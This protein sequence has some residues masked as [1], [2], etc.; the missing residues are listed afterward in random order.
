MP[1][2]NSN[3]VDS[4]SSHMLALETKPCTSKYKLLY[5][6]TANGSLEQLV[7]LMVFA[8]W[9][10]VVILWLIH[11]HVPLVY[12]NSTLSEK[13]MERNMLITLYGTSTLKAFRSER[14]WSPKLLA[15]SS[16]EA[17]SAAPRPQNSSGI[18][19]DR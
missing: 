17:S 6:G 4:A 5:D 13:I 11:A 16:G 10:T 9:V 2:K 3:L 8:T 12:G 15:P 7:Y 19:M 14:V 18:S 1:R